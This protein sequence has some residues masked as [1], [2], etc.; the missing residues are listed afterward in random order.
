MTKKKATKKALPRLRL[1]P[2]AKVLGYY[3]GRSPAGVAWWYYP[4]AGE[5]LQ[6]TA[7]KLNAQ[8]AGLAALKRAHAKRRKAGATRKRAR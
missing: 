7:R 6:E 1:H 3:L 4:R 8:A 5:T 2:E